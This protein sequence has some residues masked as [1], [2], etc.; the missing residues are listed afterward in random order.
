MDNS[1]LIR[2][3][4]SSAEEWIAVEANS[5]VDALSNGVRNIEARMKTVEGEDPYFTAARLLT[6]SIMD[7]LDRMEI[8]LA[9][10]EDQKEELLAQADETALRSSRSSE[11]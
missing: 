3:P 7:S 6:S 9:L 5:F 10:S 8:G 4:Y 1:I 2:S 11:N